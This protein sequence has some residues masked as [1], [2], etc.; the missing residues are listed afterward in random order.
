MRELRVGDITADSEWV[1][2]QV[3]GKRERLVPV[4]ETWESPPLHLLDHAGQ[5]RDALRH[6]LTERIAD[7]READAGVAGRA[8]DDRPAGFQRARHSRAL[9]DR[10]G[11]AILDRTAGI[12][13]LGLAQDFA[14]RRVG[15]AVQAHQR[16]IADQ[17]DDG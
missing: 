16:S 3:R 4:L 2:V 12:Q 6:P 15:Q 13:K 5:L 10:Q 17:V 8:L 11:R 1:L 9:H 7:E 14:A